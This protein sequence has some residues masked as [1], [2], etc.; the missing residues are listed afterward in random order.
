MGHL[1]PRNTDIVYDQNDFAWHRSMYQIVFFMIYEG[2][3]SKKLK[4]HF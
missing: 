4:Y 3:G 1:K 2:D